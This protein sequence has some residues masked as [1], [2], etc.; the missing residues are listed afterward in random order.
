VVVVV[1]C[2]V[3]VVIDACVV[4]QPVGRQVPVSRMAVWSQ[5][6]PPQDGFGFVQLRKR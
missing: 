5:Y 3:V 4:V 6:C 2:C 1:A